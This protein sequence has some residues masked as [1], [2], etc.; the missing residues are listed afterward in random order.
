LPCLLL[1]LI[2]FTSALSAKPV[3][4]ENY[5]ALPQKSMFALSPDGKRVAFRKTS[6]DLDAF[7]VSDLSTGKAIDA[8]NVSQVKP[9][10]VTF[11]NNN[12][13]ALFASKNM[14]LWGYRGRHDVSAAYA[15]NIQANTLHQLLAPGY[16]IHSGQSGLGNIIGVSPDGKYAYMPA[17]EAEITSRFSLHRVRIDKKR[18]PKVHQKGSSDSIDFFLNDQGEV[19]ARERYHNRKNLHVVE[20]KLSGT[21]TTI[22]EKESKFLTRSFSGVTPDMQHLVMLSQHQDTKRWA[23]Y[24]LSLIDGEVSE[25]IFTHPDKDVEQ[26][27]EGA[28][29]RVYGVKY[30]GFTPSYEF[31]DPKLN[32][33][34]K[35]IA[36]ALPGMS[37]SV[38]DFTSDWDKIIVY[39]EG[40]GSSGMFLLYE[41]GGISLLGHARPDIPQKNVHSVEPYQYQAR[42]GMTIPSLL[43]RPNGLDVVNL[44]AIIMPHGGPESYDRIGFNYMAQYF[45]NQGYLVIQPQFRGSEGFGANHLLAGRGEW[46]RKMQDDLTD[47]V[48]HL[49]KEGKVD[50]SRVCI[51]G[52]SYGGYAALAGAAFTPDLY[53]CVVSI[54]GVSDVDAMLR[55]EKWDYGRDHWVVSYWET[56]IAK[57]QINKDHLKDISPINHAKHVKAPVL[58]VHGEQD[59]VVPISQSKK[60]YSALKKQDKQVTFLTLDKGDHGLS[61]KEN[62]MRAMLAIDK[63][64]KKH[65]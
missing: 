49:V 41:D 46:G 44:P 43:T 24:T 6:H 35:G 4:V 52:A 3:S 40:A 54:N 30:S 23:Y 18:K 48:Q 51:V 45:A 57:G 38:V 19:I 59:L 7:Y 64:I 8:V 53:Q 29:G 36:K 16:G 12:I 65:I 33:R 47:A 11:L 22:F 42:D 63:F 2:L 21:W 9:D 50:G 56:V 61:K 17:F 32:A 60:M 26:I 15:R 31:F 58:L 13:Y 55:Q 34:I 25:P 14:R 1:I 10:G 39:A 62:R 28:N 5:A 20:S 27:V 37:V